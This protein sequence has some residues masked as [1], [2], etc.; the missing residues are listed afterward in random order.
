MRHENG[1]P[2]YA[3]WNITSMTAHNTGLALPLDWSVIPG[4]EMPDQLYDEVVTFCTRAYAEDFAVLMPTLRGRVHV[5]GRDAGRL[6]THALWVTRWLQVGL[7]SPLRT[8]AVEA[9]A[10]DQDCRCRGYATQVMRRIAAEIEDFELAVLSAFDPVWYARVGWELWRG[11]LFIRTDAGLMPTPD[12]EVMILR[13][14]RTP[15]LDLDSAL[16]AEWREGE[17]W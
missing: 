5:L 13:L 14:P 10:T 16:S 4:R 1:S 15:P 2:T 11:P 7:S 6:V 9:V 12:E 3:N 8:A 17:V